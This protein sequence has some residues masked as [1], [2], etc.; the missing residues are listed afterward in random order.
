MADTMM[1]M[2]DLILTPFIAIFLFFLDRADLIS[3]LSTA[4]ATWKA[5][6]EWFKFS[7]LRFEVQRMYLETMAHGGPYITTNDPD[8]LPYVY[9]DAVVRHEMLRQ[10]SG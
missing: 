4:F 2:N 7:T 8:Y 6:S 9:A 1:R 10:R 5:W 3:M